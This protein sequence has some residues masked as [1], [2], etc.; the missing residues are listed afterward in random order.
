MGGEMQLQLAMPC[1]GMEI[2]AFRDSPKR[3]TAN[4]VTLVWAK[5]RQRL[6]WSTGRLIDWAGKHIGG[7]ALDFS[8]S[9][10]SQHTL[11]YGS[12]GALVW[13]LVS[14]LSEGN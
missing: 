2:D 11:L 9:S 7:K 12:V 4:S 6:H 1:H 13:K 3:T 5:I 10:L 14:Q 8:F